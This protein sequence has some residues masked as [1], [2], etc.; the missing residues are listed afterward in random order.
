M[1]EGVIVRNLESLRVIDSMHD[2]YCIFLLDKGRFPRL[3]A[4]PPSLHLFSFFHPHLLSPQWL[5]ISCP[6]KGEASVHPL[7]AKM[8]FSLAVTNPKTSLGIVKTELKLS[9]TSSVASW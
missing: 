9:G 4:H 3:T 7:F 5:L 6:Y 2:F 8:G 1:Y